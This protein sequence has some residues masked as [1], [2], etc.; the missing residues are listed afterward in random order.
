[1]GRLAGQAIEGRDLILVQAAVLVLAT[2]VV[3]TN[4]LVDIARRL[5]DPRVEL[6]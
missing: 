6:A 4:L 1:V 3:L 5:I 2:L